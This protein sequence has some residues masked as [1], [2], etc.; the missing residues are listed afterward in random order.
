MPRLEI[1]FVSLYWESQ[2][3]SIVKGVALLLRV[4]DKRK[5]II[6]WDVRIMPCPWPTK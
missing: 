5:R 2:I 3:D 1:G 4:V 6:A